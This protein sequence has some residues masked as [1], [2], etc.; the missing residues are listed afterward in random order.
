MGLNPPPRRVFSGGQGHN[1]VV[2]PQMQSQS[3]QNR[4]C[5][6]NIGERFDKIGDFLRKIP[7]FPE[8][9]RPPIIQFDSPMPPMFSARRT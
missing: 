9:L 2:P 3:G 4:V 6:F 1:R 7:R 5:P 8:S